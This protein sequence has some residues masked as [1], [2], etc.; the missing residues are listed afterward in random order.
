MPIPRSA[1]RR[2]RWRRT[3]PVALPLGALLWLSLPA[4][5]AQQASSASDAGGTYISI[6]WFG[7]LAVCV[8]GWLYAV[9]WMNDDAMGVGIDFR[10]WT[11]IGLGAGAPGLLLSLLVH[12]AFALLIVAAV[13]AC[14]AVYVRE[15]NKAVP[16]RFKLFARLTG[17]EGGA[18]GEGGTEERPHIE[19][20][21]T[22]EKNRSM[23]EL[24][25]AHPEL[26]ASARLLGDLLGQA[27]A[28]EAEALRVQ[29]GAEGYDVLFK[30]DGVVHRVD[31][32]EPQVGEPLVACALSFTGAGRK[33][34]PTARMTAS[35]PGEQEVRLEV[36]GVRAKGRPGFAISLPDWHPDLYK[37]GLE[38]L[39]MHKALRDRLTKLLATPRSCVVLSGLPGS[40]RTT[41]FYA[42]LSTVDIFTTDV[43]TFEDRPAA[44]LDHIEQH[45]ID[46]S[47][48]E[49]LDEILPGILRMEPDVLGIDE[50]EELG[51]L[52][53]LLEFAAEGGRSV[54]TL[55]APGSPEAIGLLQDGVDRSIL[56]RTLTCVVNQRLVRTLCEE[57]KEA[58]EPNPA[59][60]QKLGIEP[61]RAGIWF[62]PVGCRSCMN[63]GY[64]GRTGL[65]ELLL[66]NDALREIISQGKSTP[67]AVRN[68]VGR[69]GLRT[70]YQDGLLKV[71][72]GITTLEEVR[73]IL[74]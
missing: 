19:V 59:L 52:D 61:A 43:T 42:L 22:N 67:A 69:A 14:F 53:R 50:P 37:E 36:A 64:K 21:M 58:I 3:A 13:S 41:T 11:A 39:G 73:R 23:D 7:L 38:E 72:Q 48:R 27:A 18:P 1:A 16:A 10:R 55:R 32:L 46:L 6:I 68:A 35:L 63:V 66:V 8:G 26:E 45:Q 4:A 49:A 51:L 24:V 70:L 65:F 28:A 62:K 17:E 54:F 25:E 40:G 47:T 44:D 9:Q 29:A 31:A 2:V 15:R 12:G 56:G 60:L 20:A 30:L 71:R 57:C 74:K 33:D 5:L 34:K